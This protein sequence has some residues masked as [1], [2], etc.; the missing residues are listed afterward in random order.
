M[1]ILYHVSSG[2]NAAHMDAVKWAAE[3]KPPHDKASSSVYRYSRDSAPPGIN[4]G[5]KVAKDLVFGHDV[6]IRFGDHEETVHVDMVSKFS[7][8]VNNRDRENFISSGRYW[9]ETQIRPTELSEL[10]MFKDLFISGDMAINDAHA[11]AFATYISG[12]VESWILHSTNDA[13]KADDKGDFPWSFE[14]E[15]VY[16]FWAAFQPKQTLGIYFDRWKLDKMRESFWDSRENVKTFGKNSLL[17]KYLWVHDRQ[18]EGKPTTAFAI[19]E[20]A[21]RVDTVVTSSQRKGE[22]ADDFLSRS[23]RT[24][25]RQSLGSSNLALLVDCQLYA[26]AMTVRPAFVM[27]RKIFRK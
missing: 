4:I 9:Y 7:A 20:R 10:D 5:G 1:F 22:S 19:D 25:S 17:S 3:G 15:V 21:E 16:T 24:I 2:V 23:Q 8:D 12:L 27:I 6:L 11:S 14:R 13:F 26:N 18:N